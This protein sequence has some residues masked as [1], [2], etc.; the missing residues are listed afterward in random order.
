L[1]KS[2]LGYILGGFFTNS[3]GHPAGNKQLNELK[4]KILKLASPLAYR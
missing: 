1:I 4:I 2:W 3:S